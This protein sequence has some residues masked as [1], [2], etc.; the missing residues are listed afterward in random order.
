MLAAI[1]LAALVA[2]GLAV[3][4]FHRHGTGFDS[5]TFRELLTH[6]GPTPG[7]ALLGFSTPAISIVLMTLVVLGALRVRRRDVAVLAVLGPLLALLLSEVVLKPVVGRV[8]GP[9]V[10]AGF[11]VGP[12]TGSYPS[13]HETGVVSAAVVL[14]IV[15]WQLPLRRRGRLVTVAVLAFW[16]L[17]AAIGLVRNY[18]HYAT[19]TIGGAAVPIAAVLTTALLIDRYLPA[20]WHGP[21]SSPDARD[22]ASTSR[23]A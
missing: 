19:D 23:A 2:L 17:A 3:A 15:S 16:A 20:R 22:P 7:S 12:L 10:F 5:W 18:W 9:A 6:I 13:G 4:L 11:P 8:L 14:L 21:V 1:A